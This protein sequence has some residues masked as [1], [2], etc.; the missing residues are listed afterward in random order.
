[1]R[2]AV[3]AAAPAG[4]PVTVK[5]RMGIDEDHLTYRQAG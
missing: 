2:A 3:R 5:M 4:V 1:V